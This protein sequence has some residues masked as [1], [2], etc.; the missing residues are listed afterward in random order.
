MELPETA[1]RLQRIIS[2]VPASGRLRGGIDRPVGQLG[3]Y[4]AIAL[5][6]VPHKHVHV[7]DW[8]YL[9][10]KAVC[11]ARAMH[12]GISDRMR[13]FIFMGSYQSV[14]AVTSMLALR[15]VL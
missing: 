14:S 4:H 10:P 6:A 3:T 1:D 7:I 15:L 8:L 13:I 2:V 12:T 9:A 5:A 11:T